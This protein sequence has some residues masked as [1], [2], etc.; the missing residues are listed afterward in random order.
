MVGRD[1]RARRRG[2]LTKGNEHNEDLSLGRTESLVPMLSS[3]KNSDFPRNA[4]E[5]FTKYISEWPSMTFR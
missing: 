5:N 3:V 2:V 1:R 4:S